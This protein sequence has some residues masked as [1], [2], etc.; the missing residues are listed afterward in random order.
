M[1]LLTDGEISE[2]NELRPGVVSPLREGVENL[3]H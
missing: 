2:S 3:A 1:F